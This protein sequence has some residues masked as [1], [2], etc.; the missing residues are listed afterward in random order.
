MLFDMRLWFQ[1]R[2]RKQVSIHFGCFPFVITR[3][4]TR[5]NGSTEKGTVLLLNAYSRPTPG[6]NPIAGCALLMHA[7]V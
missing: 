5:M 2:R 1:E 3:G 4:S 7:V 6:V